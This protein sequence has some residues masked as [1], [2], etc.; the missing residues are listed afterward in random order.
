M[1]DYLKDYGFSQNPFPIT[2]DYK[3]T[4]W[5]GRDEVKTILRDVV[6]SVLA[7]DTGLS[8]FVILLGTYGSGKTHAL[9]Y[10]HTMINDIEKDAFKSI[11][12]Y[13]P[14]VQVAPKISFLAIYF[15]IIQELGLDLIR[16]LADQIRDKVK[17]A[18]DDIGGTLSR[19]EERTLREQDKDYFIK[20]V[21]EEIPKEDHPMIRFL[22]DFAN[23]NAAV[24]KYLYEGKPVVQGTDFTQPINTDYM[25]TKVISSLFR[26]M[27]LS[28]GDLEP[29]YNGVQLFI[30]EVE[31]VTE[32]TNAEQFAFWSAIRELVN[33]SPY[34]FALVLSF[35]ADTALLEALI[36]IAV[37]ERTSRQNIELQAL[38]IDEAKEFLR[39]HLESFRPEGYESHQPYYP[40]AE[41]AVDYIFE[42]TVQLI[43]RKIFRKLRTVFERAVRREGLQPGDEIDAGLAEEIMVSMGL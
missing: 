18:A 34:R 39:S 15:Q 30:D 14:K 38:E 11:A 40:F 35:S 29:I 31:D 33:R 3:V 23:G 43:P 13:V 6:T 27:T 7:T 24:G 17:Q 4:N 28:I 9:R 26:A 10:F 32:V 25:A 16:E 37:A 12:I 41:E 5:A 36:P 8:E 20:R 2:P 42:Q 22:L 19:E 1:Y 21:I